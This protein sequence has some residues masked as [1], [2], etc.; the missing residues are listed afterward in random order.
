MQM[1]L[2]LIL[3]CLY[4]VSISAF[5]DELIV[6]DSSQYQ[7]D[8]DQFLKRIQSEKKKDIIRDVNAQVKEKVIDS[9]RTLR[10]SRQQLDELSR[11]KYLTPQDLESGEY[12]QLAEGSFIE[13]PLESEDL[14]K[15]FLGTSLGLLVIDYDRDLM[16]FVQEHKNGTTEKIT[17]F[18]NAMGHITG[19]AP[20]AI[21][22]Y[23]FGMIFKDDKLKSV[24]IY[25]VGAAVATQLVAEGFKATFGRERPGD[26]DNPMDFFKGGKSFISGHTTGAFSL[27]TVIAEIY[28]EDYPVIPYLAYGVAAITAYSRMHHES[29]WA[30]DTIVAAVCAHLIT[31]YFI[32]FFKKEIDS[33]TELNIYPVISG[34]GSAGFGFKFKL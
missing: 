1:K 8:R 12:A 5:G 2:I 33:S 21:G 26:S 17:E 25:T 29:H 11:G 24:G 18:G 6:K 27:A 28:K 34:N 14:A 13:I 20:V 7:T 23:F 4:L 31:K 9:P 16:D 22:S 15:F 32:K 30:S 19:I 3:C 10:I